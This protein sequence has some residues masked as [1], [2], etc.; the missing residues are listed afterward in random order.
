V[1]IS[2]SKA[3]HVTLAAQGFYALRRHDHIGAGQL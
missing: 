3:R 1:E 2:L